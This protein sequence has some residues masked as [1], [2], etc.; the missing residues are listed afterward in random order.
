MNTTKKYIGMHNGKKRGRTFQPA[1]APEKNKKA[2]KK[3][4]RRLAAYDRVNTTVRASY[5]KP[6]SMKAH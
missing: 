1:V 4:S 3:L 5:T 2:W 6:G